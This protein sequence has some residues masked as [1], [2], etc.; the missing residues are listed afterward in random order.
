MILSWVPRRHDDGVSDNNVDDMTCPAMSI[1]HNDA[2][3]SIAQ[4]RAV[5]DELNVLNV[6]SGYE[7]PWHDALDVMNV[8]HDVTVVTASVDSGANPD[9]DPDKHGNSV[10]ANPS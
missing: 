5:R 7:P 6:E 4:R 9:A 8:Y 10:K 2:T 1:R 3:T